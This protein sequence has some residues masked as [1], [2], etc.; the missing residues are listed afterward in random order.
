[1]AFPGSHLDRAH[2]R[3]VTVLQELGAEVSEEKP[4]VEG[5]AALTGQVLGSLA[6]PRHPPRL[7]SQI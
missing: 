4:H 2:E 6:T 1:M 5:G 7:L 3:V